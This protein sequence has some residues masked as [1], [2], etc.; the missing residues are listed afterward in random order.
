MGEDSGAGR[1]ASA[2]TQEMTLKCTIECARLSLEKWR[3]EEDGDHQV[4]S[5]GR[6]RRAA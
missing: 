4:L 5:C 3:I 6:F 1:I 2:L